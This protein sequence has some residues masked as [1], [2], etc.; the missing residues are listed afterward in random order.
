MPVIHAKETGG[1]KMNVLFL[2]PVLPHRMSAVKMMKRLARFRPEFVQRVAASGRTVVSVW[3]C[4]TRDGLGPLVRIQ[5]AL[6]ADKCSNILY[7]VGLPH[8]TSHITPQHDCIFQ[9]DR[10]PVDTA[11]KVDRLLQQRGVTVIM[12][13]P[14]SP[15]LNIIENVWGRMKT[16]LSR[17]GLHGKSADDLWAAVNEEWER[18]KCDSS[19]TEAQYRSLPERMKAVIAGGGGR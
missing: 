16:S 13:P 3:G 19:F 12:W 11:K 6:T 2:L 8:I 15:D 9:H 7:T 1:V 4:I 17:L 10:S 5:G 14:Q 18:L